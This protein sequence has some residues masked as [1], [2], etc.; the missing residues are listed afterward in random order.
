MMRAGS[1]PRSALRAAR[2]APVV[3]KLLAAGASADAGLAGDH[4]AIDA[5]LTKPLTA[6]TLY[7]AVIE[8]RRK[9]ASAATGAAAG[10]EIS[11]V[12]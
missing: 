5:V 1:K 6:S 8:A 11:A 10:S 12:A 2:T 4:G 7:N 9:R 3:E